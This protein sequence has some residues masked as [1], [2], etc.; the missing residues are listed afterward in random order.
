M[1]GKRVVLKVHVVILSQRCYERAS[2]RAL[3]L[4][5]LKTTPGLDSEA[6]GFEQDMRALIQGNVLNGLP[7]TSF[8]YV[9][10]EK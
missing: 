4:A 6:W 7:D 10:G 1:K 3:R 8:E 2:L 9:R 5:C